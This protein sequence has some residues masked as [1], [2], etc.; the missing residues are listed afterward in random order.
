MGEAAGLAIGIIG[1]S[2]LFNNAVDCFE[3]VQI[4]R[5]FGRDFQTSLLKLDVARLRLTRWGESVG[6]GSALDEAQS[7]ESTVFS[8]KAV[9]LA[10]RILGQIQDLFADAERVSQ[11]FQQNP[12]HDS[13]ADL[14]AAPAS[15]H[16]KMRDLAIRRQGRA[17][18]RKKAKWA[19]YEE[20]QLSRLIEDIHDLVNDLV[21]LLPAVDVQQ[22]LCEAEIS[23]MDREA[24]LTLLRDAAADQD[25]LL[26]DAIGKVIGSPSASC[27]VT[28]FQNSPL[29]K[30]QIRLLELLPG[31]N[32]S[33][34]SGNL[35]VVDLDSY[36]L[37]SSKGAEFEAL[38]YVW[39]SEKKPYSLHT[40]TGCIALTES[41][42]VFLKRIRQ[43]EGRRLLWADAACIN[44]DDVLEKE[45]QVRLMSVIYSTANRVIADLGEASADTESTLQFMD[46]YWR[47][48][49]WAGGDVKSFGKATTSEEVALFLGIPFDE[50]EPPEAGFELP[51]LDDER[52]QKLKHF[53]SRPWFTRLWI[54]QEFVLAKD[55]LFH[56]GPHIIDW[57]HLVASCIAYGPKAQYQLLSCYNLHEMRD[58][59]SVS[60]FSIMG[61]LRCIRTLKQSPGGIGFLQ[62]LSAG[63]LWK[64][65]SRFHLVDL[66]QYFRNCKCKL[67]RDRYFALLQVAS[68]LSP[69]DH[70]D[71]AVDYTTDTNEL[72]LRIGRLLIQQTNGV[73]MFLRS[74][75]WTSPAAHIPSWLQDFAR[76]KTTVFD[77]AEHEST[78]SA[79][80]DTT[81]RVLLCTD[82]SN[83]IS[84][85]GYRFD[86]VKDTAPQLTVDG[87]TILDDVVAYVKAGCEIV[88][89]MNDGKWNVDILQ[90]V[91]MTLCANTFSVAETRSLVFGFCLVL[92]YS[93]Q[94]QETRNW[95]DAS[96]ELLQLLGES[97]TITSQ[98]QM[99]AL[100]AFMQEMYV[101]LLQRLRPSITQGGHFANLP[102]ITEPGDEIWIIQGCRLPVVLRKSHDYLSM[103]R[104]VGSCYCHGIMKGEILDQDNFSFSDVQIH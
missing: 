75:L 38:S 62:S 11:R 32:E 21:G 70:P 15:L 78:H 86:E 45:S 28:T 54:V 66:L 12:A 37:D 53:F 34:L 63:R 7:L 31:T 49:I 98:E 29:R 87:A 57:R 17:G 64:Q 24:D 19:L 48:A 5:G 8:A 44:Q 26:S 43:Q 83:G 40:P 13:I 103:Y 96:R 60:L 1:L 14:D 10:E 89:K 59:P 6:L 23:E 71:L 82:S 88:G 76:S 30:G 18:L 55:V 9:P 99:E 36:E 85:K 47:T 92:I 51:A 94:P 84:V 90:D 72:V 27:N 20:K 101:P 81:F 77:L 67:E 41:L 68:D 56:C 65:F 35:H 80:G 104:L 2:G 95:E 74:G 52:W 4:G 33:P 25:K 3:Y 102:L 39:G 16:Q 61:F 22:R 97:Q 50:L 58:T 79:A 73:E 46:S 69:D 42:Y 91:A 100:Y 93:Y